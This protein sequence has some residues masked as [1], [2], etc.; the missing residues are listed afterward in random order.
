[1]RLFFALLLMAAAIRAESPVAPHDALTPLEPRQL[2]E[3]GSAAAASFATVPVLDANHEESSATSQ[4]EPGPSELADLLRYGEKKLEAEDFESSLIAFQQVMTGTRQPKERERALAGLARTYRK[5][6]DLVKAAAA[7]ERLLQDHEGATQAPLYLL[8]LGRTLRALGAPKLATA[9]FYGVLHAVLK[10][11]PGQA[12]NYRQIARTAQF[13]IA[14]THFQVGDF[15]EAARFFTR[16]N[17]LDLAPADRARAEFKAAQ[18]RAR[19]GDTEAAIAGYRRLL[20]RHN[21]SE[22]AAEARFQL[23][24]LLQQVGRPNEALAVT[25]DLLRREQHIAEQDAERWAYWQRRTGNQLANEFYNRGDFASAFMIYSRLAE[26]GAEPRWRLPVLYQMALC[27]ER[28]LQSA[29]ARELYRRIRTEVGP[30]PASPELSEIDRMAAWRL[31]QL[32]WATETNRQIET[33]SLSTHP[34]T[35]PATDL[36]T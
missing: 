18:S 36:D 2:P 5:T 27:Q 1:M 13:E 11:P 14:E 8:E 9:R 15:E 17:L 10:V 25:L 32:E 24:T 23:A 16:L 28:L 33:L 29:A 12:E 21:D 4:P 30:K 22:I 34:K 26:L 20:D 7:Y 3:E 6:G 19:F 35:P 31:D